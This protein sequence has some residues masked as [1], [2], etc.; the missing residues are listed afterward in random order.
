MERS[1]MKCPECDTEMDATP[2]TCSTLYSCLKC[3]YSERVGSSLLVTYPHKD[4]LKK[5]K[6]WGYIKDE[7]EGIEEGN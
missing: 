2:A 1:N 7:V 6:Y 5:H 3:G 4:Y